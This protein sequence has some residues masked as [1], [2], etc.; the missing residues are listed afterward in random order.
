MAFWKPTSSGLRGITAFALQ[1]SDQCGR[2]TVSLI[3]R[4]CSVT[5][6]GEFGQMV[7]DEVRL[8]IARLAR[9]LFVRNILSDERGL[10][11]VAPRSL[12]VAEPVVADEERGFRPNAHLRN[13]GFKDFRMRFDSADVR[14]D[15]DG[16]KPAIELM[17]GEAVSNG[18]PARIVGDQSEPEARLES[19]QKI[20][21][22]ARDPHAGRHDI[23][24]H[25][26]QTIELVGGRCDSEEMLDRRARDL[27]EVI[28]AELAGV[29]IAAFAMLN[30][31]ELFK[32]VRAEHFLEGARQSAITTLHLRGTELD[33]RVPVIEQ[34][35]F[36]LR[37]Q[38]THQK[39][40][41][42]HWT[43]EM[44]RQIPSI[45]SR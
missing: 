42:N 38:M 8:V 4:N 22:F 13:G 25:F 10:H 23:E 18:S 35:G 14:R 44:G 27:G 11:T 3:V 20:V 34:N 36:Q 15:D 16:F 6:R 9:E 45:S 19:F 40:S 5:K 7:D 32:V 17:F 41:F 12:N 2:A 37:G 21:N 30:F 29:R 26:E 43:K 33:Q 31:G 1:V 24:A 39:G 28:L